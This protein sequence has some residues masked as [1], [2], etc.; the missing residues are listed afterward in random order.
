[1]MRERMEAQNAH[2][3]DFSLKV[4][5]WMD[6]PEGGGIVAWQKNIGNFVC[7]PLGV[8]LVTYPTSFSFEWKMGW[9]YYGLKYTSLD[10]RLNFCYFSYQL[11]RKQKWT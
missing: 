6:I 9:S 11:F 8:P 3:Q 10:F 1:M 2:L 5:A 4:I 7:G